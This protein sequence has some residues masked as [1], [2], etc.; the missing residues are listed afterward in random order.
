MTSPS[1]WQQAYQGL[2]DFVAACS[3]IKIERSGI[4][5]PHTVREDFYE[6]FDTVRRAFVNELYSALP[7]EIDSLSWNYIRA[8]TEVMGRLKLEKISM[9][10]DLHSFLHNP[11]EGLMRA[12]YN[13][14]F[15]LLQGKISLEDFRRLATQD[16]NANAAELLPLGYER[17]VALTIV[18]LLEPDKAFKVDLDSEDKPV[19]GQLTDIAFGAQTPHVTLRLPEFVVHSGRLSKYAAIKLQLTAEIVSYSAIGAAP[20]GKR[21]RTG[22][23]SFALDSR[24]MLL[25]V[26]P[27]LE[28]IPITVDLE[29]QRVSQPDLVIEC[30]GHDELGDPAV[31][32]QMKR[33]NEIFKPKFGT[34]LV[35]RDRLREMDLENRED[36]LHPL[37]VGFD[38][39][40]LN[41]I[42][43]VLG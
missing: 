43:E 36:N 15:D 7:A 2:Q 31:L 37:E 41:S 35:C 12:I 39:S 8:E 9:P 32:D 28:H 30:T 6:R 25:S 11:R 29:K 22:D 20:P 1:N 26:L 33:R 5:I 42:I 16:L 24:V 14:L 19:P 3:E 18:K 23:T 27:D 34:Y 13:R 40:K 21:R 10:I 4:A 17:W 38:P